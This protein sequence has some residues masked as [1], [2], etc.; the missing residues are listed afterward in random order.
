MDYTV[1]IKHL[2]NWFPYDEVSLNCQK[3]RD[4]QRIIINMMEEQ[5]HILPAGFKLPTLNFFEDTSKTNVSNTQVEPQQCS[6]NN[7]NNNINHNETYYN[8]EVNLGEDMDMHV[9]EDDDDDEYLELE[10]EEIEDNGEYQYNDYTVEYND[11]EEEEVEEVEEEEGEEGEYL[12]HENR[13]YG[14]EMGQNDN[15]GEETE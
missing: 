11:D 9:E 7:R 10:N 13:E 8:N 1:P 4:V 12:S 3:R 14:F 15:W 6:F 5:G 2:E